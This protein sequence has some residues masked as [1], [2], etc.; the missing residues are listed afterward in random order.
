VADILATL[1][2]SAI[3]RRAAM[4][5][6]WLD[7]HKLHS[8][9]PQIE[10]SNDSMTQTTRCSCGDECEFT[11]VSYVAVQSKKK[12]EAGYIWR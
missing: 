3:Y 10:L 2:Q 12:F 4:M 6:E 1:L 5:E 11:I 9:S 7:R 8:P